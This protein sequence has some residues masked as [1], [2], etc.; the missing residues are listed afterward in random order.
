MRALSSSFFARPAELVG[1]ELIGCRL[2]KRQTDGSL[3][4]VVVETGQCVETNSLGWK[5]F[6]GVAAKMAESPPT[7]TI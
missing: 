5:L 1:P 2:V 3:L 6:K 4:W 7:E